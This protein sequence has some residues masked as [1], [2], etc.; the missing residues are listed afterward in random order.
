MFRLPVT[1]VAVLIAVG[2]AGALSARIGGSHVG[3]AM[4][5]V[6]DR[7][8]GRVSPSRAGRPMFAAGVNRRRDPRSR[9]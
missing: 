3:H 2:L 1:F 6:G 8:P 9:F 7:R 4:L 5:R